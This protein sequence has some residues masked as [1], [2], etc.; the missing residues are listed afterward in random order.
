MP[1]NVALVEDD[2]SVS[3]SVERL[4]RLAGTHVTAF[5]SADAFLDF[6]SRRAF[7]CLILDIYIEDGIS[8]LELKEMLNKEGSRI[9]VIFFSAHDD[10]DTRTETTRVGCHTL[11]RKGDD[12]KLLLATL[13]DIEQ[14]SRQT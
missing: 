1:L 14:A 7:D 5:Q 2:A 4:L 3:R 9:P 6:P 10:I 8:G 13:Q 11:V 12:I